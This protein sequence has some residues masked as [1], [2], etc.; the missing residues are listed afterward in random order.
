MTNTID[1]EI[2]IHT[3][4][5]LHRQIAIVWSI[6]DVQEVRPDLTEDQCWQVLQFAKRGHDAECGINWETLEYVACALFGEAP[7]QD[8]EDE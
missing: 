6:E 4:L 8:D 7:C 2:D 5:A 3:L 1:T